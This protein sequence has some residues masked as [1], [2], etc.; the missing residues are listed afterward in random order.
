M[1]Q[2]KGK[3]SKRKIVKS[4]NRKKA[5]TAIRTKVLRRKEKNKET[6]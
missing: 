2:T 4:G 6:R 5:N 3:R 1:G